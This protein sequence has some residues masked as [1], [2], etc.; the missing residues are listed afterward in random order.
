MA[1]HAV[2]HLQELPSKLHIIIRHFCPFVIPV[3]PTDKKIIQEKNLSYPQ[4]ICLTA[5]RLADTGRAHPEAWGLTPRA[6]GPPKK[7]KIFSTW[8]CWRGSAIQRHLLLIQL[9]FIAH[10]ISSRTDETIIVVQIEF[11]IPL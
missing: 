4:I 9:S 3:Y 5:C 8:G 6:A 1:K 7:N 10:P 2:L 11:E